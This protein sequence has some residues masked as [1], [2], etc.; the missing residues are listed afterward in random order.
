VVLVGHSMGA[1]AV[2]S[3]AGQR[4]DLFERKVI[5]VGLISA[6]AGD[7]E[8]IDFGLGRRLGMLVHRLGPAAVSGL[9]TR[10]VMF[11]SARAAGKDVEE[12]LVHHYSFASNV[13]LAVVRLTADMIFRTNLHVIGAFFTQLMLHDEIDALRTLIGTEMLVMHGVQDR[14]TP[15]E[16]GQRI[17]EA[18]PGCEY[19]EVMRAGH[20]LP[21]E[22]PDV[23]SSELL[24]MIERARRSAPG[25][26]RGSMSRA[27]KRVTGVSSERRAKA[28][29]SRKARS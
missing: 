7:L 13:P 6:S 18:V 14:I 10:Q 17:V 23:V 9:S 16:H 24:A 27:V 26:R 28:A 25:S 3:L 11:D 21:L 29:R 2:M 20:V 19:I 12:Y 22:H 4:P 5:G 15:I 8:T 1:M